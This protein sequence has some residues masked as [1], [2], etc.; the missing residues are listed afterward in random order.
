MNDE[1]FLRASNVREHSRHSALHYFHET[2]Y[3]ET[4]LRNVRDPIPAWD[5]YVQFGEQSGFQPNPLFHPLHYK[6]M[7]N[8]G[9]GL[10]L[11]HY[12]QQGVHRLIHPHPL[13]RPTSAEQDLWWFAENDHENIQ[14][15]VTPHPGEIGSSLLRYLLA[16]DEQ[17][18]HPNPLFDRVWYRDHYFGE[19]GELLDPLTHY[20]CEGGHRGHA[21]GE[22]IE[23]SPFL[24][25][26]PDLLLQHLSP[27]EHALLHE[28]PSGFTFGNARPEAHIRNAIRNNNT[29]AA[30]RILGAWSHSSPDSWKTRSRSKAASRTDVTVMPTGDDIVVFDS[31]TFVSKPTR[32]GFLSSSRYWIDHEIGFFRDE[33]ISEELPQAI[34]IDRTTV[35]SG[36]ELKQLIKFSQESGLPTLTSRS[37]EPLFHILEPVVGKVANLRIISSPLRVGRILLPARQDATNNTSGQHVSINVVS[38]TSEHLKKNGLRRSLLPLLLE[39]MPEKSRLEIT[40]DVTVGPNLRR[41]LATTA[42]QRAIELRW[43]PGDAQNE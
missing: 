43:M 34:L 32:G 42:H 13:V 3:A 22:H 41:Q 21:T 28:Q 18:R 4:Y 35:T 7:A 26:R 10:A 5:H 20:L 25:R 14:H 12:A 37:F 16:T 36:D 40:D 1:T 8:L 23:W 31:G 11:A 39:A 19:C 29:E 15:L 24:Q 27:M 30:C 9:D 38:D 17:W 2:W 33:P 6:R